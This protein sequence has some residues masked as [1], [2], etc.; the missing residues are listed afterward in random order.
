MV[1]AG[2]LTFKIR[3]ETKVPTLIIPIQASTGSASQSN[4]ARKINKIHSN[5][6]GRD[7]VGSIFIWQNF[8]YRIPKSPPKNCLS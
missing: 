2:S 6:K 5:W 4:K 8:I 1:K 3:N 7:I